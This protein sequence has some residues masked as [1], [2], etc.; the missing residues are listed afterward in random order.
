[1]VDKSKIDAFFHGS[2]NPIW[3]ATNA[4][5]C[6]YGNPALERLTDLNSCQINRADWRSFLLEEDQAVPI[7]CGFGCEH[8][9][10]VLRQ[11]LN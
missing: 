1:M 10:R 3:L 5:D 4:D 8:E 2:T 9:S 11:L 7:M 6:V